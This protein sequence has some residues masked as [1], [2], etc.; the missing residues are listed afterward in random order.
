M[1][2]RDLQPNN[3]SKI[4]S[5]E[6][7]S[8]LEKLDFYKAQNMYCFHGSKVSNLKIL[9]PSEPVG[10]LSQNPDRE[11]TAVYADPDD[12]ILPL[13]RA[14]WR[15]KDPK[16]PQGMRISGRSGKIEIW[17][18][19][20]NI[21]WSNGSIYVCKKSNSFQDGGVAAYRSTEPIEVNAEIEV[22]PEIM[23]QLVERGEVVCHI[24]IP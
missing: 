21:E 1:K 16:K 10:D 6:G 22:G 17:G 11:Q 19:E 7:L 2:E 12:Y 3:K 15:S 5:L 4:E 14:L 20:E 13:L 9:K 18:N 8:S 24:K 23:K